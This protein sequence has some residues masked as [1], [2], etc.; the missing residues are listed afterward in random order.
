M[1]FYNA[2]LILAATIT[3]T[4]G[5][6]LEVSDLEDEGIAGDALDAGFGNSSDIETDMDHNAAPI[7]EPVIVPPSLPSMD[8]TLPADSS[9]PP[10]TGTDG[11]VP[12]EGTEGIPADNGVTSVPAD[13][14]VTSI[15]ADTSIPEDTGSQYP[16]ADGISG[17][18]VEIPDVANSSDVEPDN[19]DVSAQGV[20][21][22]AADDNGEDSDDNGDSQ[23]IDQLDGA[24]IMENLDNVDSANVEDTPAE[25]DAPEEGS[26]VEDDGSNTGGKIATGLAGVAAVSSA[27]LFWYIKKSKHAGLESVRTQ[28][29]MV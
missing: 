3:L 25:A 21:A 19:A 2:L 20:D 13:N 4:L 16:A 10:V 9:V 11:F 5:N 27:G 8:N 26:D 1:K 14:G 7:E 15:P 18:D 23:Q 6:G 24:D 28:I 22:P 17:Q 12:L 29:T